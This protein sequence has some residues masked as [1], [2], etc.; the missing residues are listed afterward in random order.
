MIKKTSFCKM[1]REE[2]FSVNLSHNYAL[3][4]CQLP[5]ATSHCF[6]LIMKIFSFVLCSSLY[7]ALVTN[8]PI[9][10]LRLQTH[11]LYLTLVSLFLVL[12]ATLL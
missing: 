9:D 12:I 4:R 2:W 11:F 10:E 5:K 6:R 7:L 3:C 8:Y 1:S